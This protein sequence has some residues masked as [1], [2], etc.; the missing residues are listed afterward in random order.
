VRHREERSR[1]VRGRWL[2]VGRGKVSD[3][4][5]HG[6]AKGLGIGWDQSERRV[7]GWRGKAPDMMES[8][9]RPCTIP[10]LEGIR[11]LEPRK[12]PRVAWRVDR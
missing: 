12:G 4:L 2:V 6:M 10:K 1:E 5:Y 7:S 9:P 11:V 8:T 3:F